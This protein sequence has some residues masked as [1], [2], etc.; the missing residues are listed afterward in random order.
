M[1]KNN[2][3]DLIT[4]QE[5]AFAHLILSGNMT[6]RQAA[7]AVGLDP[8][9]AAY[10]KAKPR[11]RDYLLEHRAAVQQQP[12]EHDTGELR[13]FNVSRDQVLTRLWDIANMDPE[14]TRN[15]MSSQV[16]ALSMIVAIEGLIPD[17]RRAVSPQN[18]PAP[19]PVAAQFYKSA[20]NRTQQPGDPLDPQPDPI[21][22]EAAPE[23][24]PTPGSAD[25]PFP[26]SSPDPEP[27]PLELSSRPELRRSAV[28]GP[29][30]PGPLDTSQTPPSL[31]RVPMADYFAPDTRVPFKI[32]KNRFRRRR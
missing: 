28:E 32:D 26:V 18:E 14:R 23:P 9:S 4:D 27:T 31:P 2:V 11:V 17:R 13:R 15:S 1:P 30:V 29:A 24:E 3:T 5:I 16:K 19:S 6:D 25:G 8:N 10:I 7:E 20:W 21:P 22:E 12:V